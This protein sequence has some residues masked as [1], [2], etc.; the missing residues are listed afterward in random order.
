M[1]LRTVDL[2]LLVVLD[3][4]LSTRHVTRAAEKVGLS[5]PAMSSALRRLRVVFHDELL[6]RTPGG[7]QPTT[8][9]VELA[10]P[11]RS[12]LRQIERVM[13]PDQHFDPATTPRTFR[14]RLSDV[15]AVLVLPSFLKGFDLLGSQVSLETVHLSPD[16]TID[17]LERDEIDV[18][19]SFG[20]VKST[21]ILSEPLMRDRMVCVVRRDHCFADRVPTM[22]EFLAA[23]HIRVSMSPTDLRFVDDVIT[24][25]GKK[26]IVVLNVPHW[27]VVPKL[28]RGTDFVTVMPERLFLALDKED[29]ASCELPFCSDGFEWTLYWHRRQDRNP[30]IRWMRDQ[31]RRALA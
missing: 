18:A 3:A 29:L 30:A 7:M 10:E 26:R 17:A 11:V 23:K 2:N 16:R 21:T 27:L 1:N 28:L 13:E 24:A 15:L 31:L 12:V 19:V 9:A 4:L 8:R 25:M 22:D 20:L 5:Q 14:I 6:V